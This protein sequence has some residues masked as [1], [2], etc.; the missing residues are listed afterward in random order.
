MTQA[1]TCGKCSQLFLKT[2]KDSE[3]N[4]PSNNTCS[5]VIYFW[6]KLTCAELYIYHFTLLLYII[7]LVGIL[8]FPMSVVWCLLVAATGQTEPVWHQTTA[9]SGPSL[10][11]G[12]RHRWGVTRGDRG[13]GSTGGSG[14]SDHSHGWNLESTQK[15]GAWLTGLKI[16]IRLSLDFSRFIYSSHQALMLGST[17]STTI[18]TLWRVLEGFSFPE[19]MF[20]SSFNL[21]ISLVNHS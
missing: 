12:V 13:A 17:S 18:L 14:R 9:G 16:I 1:R 3:K 21:R 5:L 19:I 6:T 8:C 15:K 10:G 20:I 11:A 7:I 2:E 4:K